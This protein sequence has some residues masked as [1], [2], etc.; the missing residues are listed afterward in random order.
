MALTPI[1]QIV[2]RVRPV[3]T[4]PEL[5]DFVSMIDRQARLLVKVAT[6]ASEIIEGKESSHAVR[7]LELEQRR[8]ELKR[9]NYAALD[10]IPN[11]R[12]SID[13][14]RST[15]DALD[16]AAARLFVTGRDFHQWCSDSDE[17]IRRMMTVIRNAAGSLQHGYAQLRNGSSAAEFD[18]DEAIGCKN[19]MD[20]HRPLALRETTTSDQQ[21]PLPPVAQVAPKPDPTS[22]VGA[23]CQEDLYANLNDIVEELVGAGIILRN[24]SQGLATDLQ[25]RRDE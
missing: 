17:A 21:R 23:S 6:T 22:L 7:L 14:I 16:R 18:A 8:E 5:A 12:P 9:R 13:E 10:S 25:G 15:M 11:L 3:V 24:W 2:R 1:S 19:A 4:V 20:R